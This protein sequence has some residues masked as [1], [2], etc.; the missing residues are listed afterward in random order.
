MDSSYSKG[1][2]ELSAAFF[3][4]AAIPDYPRDLIHSD[5]PDW[6][7]DDVGLEVVRAFSPKTIELYIQK[8][9]KGKTMREVSQTKYD[10]D[11]HVLFKFEHDGT[12][13]YLMYDLQTRAISKNFIGNGLSLDELPDEEREKVLDCAVDGIGNNDLEDP[14]LFRTMAIGAF[15]AKIDTLNSPNYN[16]RGRND[17]FI[18]CAD[19][20]DLRGID[21]LYGEMKRIQSGHRCQYS[22]VFV[23]LAMNHVM[24]DIDLLGGF[25]ETIRMKWICWEK[26]H[27]PKH[28]DVNSAHLN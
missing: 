1:D 8:N 15:K 6:L 14:Y 3:L 13:D 26:I 4:C 11:G 19:Y 27:W 20:A 9:A 24:V 25:V 28:F 12:V 17:L 7:S 2:S 16:V 21:D 5:F 22:H 18:E 23:H 10:N